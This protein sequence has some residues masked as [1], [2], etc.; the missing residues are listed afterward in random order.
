MFLVIILDLEIVFTGE[1][2]LI[3]LSEF[4]SVYAAFEA[5]CVHSLSYTIV[6]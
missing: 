5:Y 2:K 4:I 1:A 6:V 3:F